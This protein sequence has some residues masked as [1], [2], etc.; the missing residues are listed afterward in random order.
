M[1]YGGGSDKEDPSG[2]TSGNENTEVTVPE[3]CDLSETLSFVSGEPIKPNEICFTI[4]FCAQESQVETIHSISF[5][6]CTL[7]D[8]TSCARGRSCN[9]RLNKRLGQSEIDQICHLLTLDPPP[10]KLT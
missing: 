4:D 10:E 6:E 9:W 1:A 3:G 2:E 5:A 7:V 8:N